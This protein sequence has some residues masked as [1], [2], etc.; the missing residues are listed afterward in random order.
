MDI[1]INDYNRRSIVY[2]L[3]VVIILVQSVDVLKKGSTGI[4]KGKWHI[5][6]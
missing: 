4:T 6:I 5:R 2:F 3:L 1:S